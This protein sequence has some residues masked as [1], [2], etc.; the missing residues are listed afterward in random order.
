MGIEGLITVQRVLPFPPVFL[1]GHAPGIARFTNGAY[2]GVILVII[3]HHYKIT[4][5][6]AGLTG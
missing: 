4:I 3:R 1:A 2:L 5:K 6:P